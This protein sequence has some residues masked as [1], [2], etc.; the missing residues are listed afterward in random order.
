MPAAKISGHDSAQFTQSQEREF[1]NK[2]V[3]AGICGILLGAF[4]VHKFI[5]GLNTGGVIMLVASLAGA[6]LVVP[7]FVM[8]VIG[9]VEGVIYI[10]KTDEDFYQTYSVEKKEWF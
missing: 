3:A 5:L 4:G 9:V 6:F 7:T 2:K 10:T 8:G 1:C